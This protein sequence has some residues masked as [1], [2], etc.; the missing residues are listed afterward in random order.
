MCSNL[1]Q[2]YLLLLIGQHCLGD[3]PNSRQSQ[4]ACVLTW[5]GMYGK[6]RTRVQ[7]CNIRFGSFILVPLHLSSRTLNSPATQDQTAQISCQQFSLPVGYALKYCFHGI[8]SP[9][10][11]AS[12]SVYKHQAW[13][14]QLRHRSIPH[15]T[16]VQLV[17]TTATGEVVECGEEQGVTEGIRGSPEGDEEEEQEAEEDEEGAG[18]AGAEAE[19]HPAPRGQDTDSHGFPI[20]TSFY[21]KPA[22][23]PA[24]VRAITVQ[25]TNFGGAGMGNVRALAVRVADATA[26]DPIRHRDL[27]VSVLQNGKGEHSNRTIAVLAKVYKEN[28]GAS[29]HRQNMGREGQLCL[30]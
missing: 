18:T 26:D 16:H 11:T 19:V 7:I 2:L 10:H 29:L 21:I 28:V 3:L 5:V 22:E 30:C 6:R 23:L 4:G 17:F 25:A 15:H 12:K 9:V 20:K 13:P 24:R 27:F 14:D 1:K 8:H